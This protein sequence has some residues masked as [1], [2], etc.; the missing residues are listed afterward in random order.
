MKKATGISG[1]T[2]QNSTCSCAHPVL[3]PAVF[4]VLTELEF[5]LGGGNASSI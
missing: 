4:R 2:Y 3:L 1:Y 5:R